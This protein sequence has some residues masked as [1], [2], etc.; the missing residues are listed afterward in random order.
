MQHVAPM[1]HTDAPA[2][3]ISPLDELPIPY[4]S[5]IITSKKLSPMA[6]FDSSTN[7]RSTTDAVIKDPKYL[8]MQ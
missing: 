5:L 6:A 7:R 2:H 3:A 8:T 4:E 1:M